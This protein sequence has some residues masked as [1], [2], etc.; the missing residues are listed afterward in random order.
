[1]MG[2]ASLNACLNPPLDC[3]TNFVN[4]NANVNKP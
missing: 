1:M 3:F 4:V 2:L